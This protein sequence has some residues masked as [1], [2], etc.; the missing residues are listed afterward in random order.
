MNEE[1]IAYLEKAIT[2][3]T[4]ENIM[5]LTFADVERKKRAILAELDLSKAN[6]AKLLKQL[7][8]YRYIDEL[9]ELQLGR[10]LRWINLANSNPD[11][12]KLT[13]GGILCEINIED[14]VV[15]VLKNKR[16]DF[17]RIN[18]DKSLIFQR[19]SDQERVILYA[20]DYL[21]K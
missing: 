4:N 17:F 2:N 19:L 8:D 12:I 7:D 21:Q 10:Y 6:T 3:E 11:Q 20:T 16:N 13:N 15:L 14:N 9:P 5:N 18:M 1:E